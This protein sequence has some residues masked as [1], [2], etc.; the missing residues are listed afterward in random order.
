NPV[1]APLRP[2]ATGARAFLPDGR[3]VAGHREAL[4]TGTRY[5]LYTRV[6]DPKGAAPTVG[7]DQRLDVDADN[8]TSGSSIDLQN[9]GNGSLLLQFYPGGGA[10]RVRV[11]SHD[12]W[13]PEIGSVMS[14]V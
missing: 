11:F 8:L 13:S 4:D 9:L 6:V 12:K 10:R 7:A 2:I 14:V 5:A 1:P 3:S